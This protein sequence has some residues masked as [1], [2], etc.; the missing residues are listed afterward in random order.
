ME[1]KDIA[2]SI[3]HLSKIYKIFDSPGQRLKSLLFKTNAGRDF[4]AL[5]DIN[6]EIKKGEAFAIIG[7][8]GSGKSTM[9]QLLAGIIKPTSG[10]VIVNGRIAALLELGSGFDP[11]S[12]GYENIYM[13]AATLGLGK[14]EIEEKIQEIIEFAD[15]GEHLYQP[16]KTYSSG[17]YVRL[18][19][20]VAINVDADILLVD[21]ALAVGDV[22]FRQKCYTRLNELKKKGVTIIL[23][24][25]NM[26]E[27][28]QFCDRALFLRAGEPINIG[29]SQE[30][31]KE[32]YLDNASNEI[33]SNPQILNGEVSIEEYNKKF[34]SGW[35][36]KESIFF[37]L[38]KSNEMS[39]GK[40]T[41]NKIGLFD[42]N[43][44]IQRVF[45]QGEW[46]YFYGELD[47][48]E[49][50]L[51]PMFGVA[52]YNE[53]NIIVHGK[54]TI[55]TYT[56]LPLRVKKNSKIHF[57]QK[58]K[59]DIAVG[60]YTFETGFSEVAHQTYL[61]R[62]DITQELIDAGCNVLC[63]RNNVGIFSVVDKQKGEPTRMSFHGICDLPGETE[64]VVEEC[65]KPK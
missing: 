18:G 34:E 50:I 15:I 65:G 54:N 2:V 17:M 30:I 42:K 56:K 64:I 8:N 33:F 11:E 14:E 37:D 12:T 4:Q 63:V 62:E 35:S 36:I 58:I 5:D 59:F 27:V 48:K 47:I 9:L 24:T 39:N 32:Y 10:E 41:F 45:E 40:A 25:H 46:G 51:M 44:K 20:A 23:V 55:Q 19:F 21:E 16:V 38:E 28:E 7:K 61:E 22:F 57:L 53:K 29:R 26:S 43:G 1:Q 60:E 3:K 52:L 13:N 31:V 49:E 6:L